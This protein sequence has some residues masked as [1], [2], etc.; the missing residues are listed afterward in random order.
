[1]SELSQQSREHLSDASFAYIDSKGERHLPIHDEEHVRNAAS[2]FSQTHF[3][4]ADARHTA[5]R[6]IL[7]AARKYGVDLADDDAVSRAAHPS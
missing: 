6:H 1:M 4:S 5:A 2:R 3:E 7:A